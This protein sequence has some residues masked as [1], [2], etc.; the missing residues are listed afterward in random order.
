[1]RTAVFLDRD[2]TLIEDKGVLSHPSQIELLPYAIGALHKLQRA[3]D[4]FVITNQQGISQGTVTAAEVEAVNKALDAI[5]KQEG[6][7][8]QEWYVC[9]HTR[10]DQCACRKPA[11]AFLLE[12]AQNHGVTLERSFVIGDHPSDALT[13]EAEG[14]FGLY[15]LTGH[16]RK[17]LHELIEDKPVF[18]HLGDAAEWILSHPRGRK[19]LQAVIEQGAAALKRGG[20]VAFPTETVYGLGADVFKKA[21]VRRIFDVKERPF[22]NPLIVHVADVSD[23]ASLVQHLDDRAT[24][25]MDIFWPG[26]LTLILP[27]SDAVPDIV[28]AGLP[29]VA[30]RM[31][32]SSIARALIEKAGTPLAAPSANAFGRTSPTTAAHVREQLEGRYDVLID[33]GACRVGVES[34]VLSLADERLRIL[35]PGGVTKDQI[36]AVAGPVQGPVQSAPKIESPGMLPSHYAPH[37]PLV[38]SNE[39]PDEYM[40]AAD[41]GWLLFQPPACPIEGPCEVL[42]REGHME[43][44]AIHLYAALRRLDAQGLRLL[45]AQR[46]PEEGIG[47]A[48]NDRLHKAANEGG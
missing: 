7:H 44:A 38:L 34:T 9:P 2:G 18:H 20:L 31:P 17:H 6:I 25:L 26:P 29:N 32:A 39:P 15:V 22:S 33:G 12:A 24:R 23:V 4:L 19:D 28:T 41:V 42:S 45:V 47:I 35:R 36:E 16:G 30:V 46:F 11:S 5:L 13:G 27:K 8:I 21:A 10:E 48:I 14:V 3:F 1:M 43:E 40:H 37:T